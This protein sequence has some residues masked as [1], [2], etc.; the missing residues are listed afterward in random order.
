MVGTLV[1]APVGTSTSR[2][3]VLTATFLLMMDASI[4]AL[5]LMPRGC[6]ILMTMSST[7]ARFMDPPQA[8]TPPTSSVTRFRLSASMATSQNVSTKS[9]VP[10]ALLMARED[11]LGIMTPAAATMDT[12]MGVILLPGTPPRLWKSN[13][14]GLSNSIMSPVLAMALVK[15]AI[16]SISM[17]L[18]YRAVSH[19]EISI[20]DSLLFR[21]STTMDSISSFD[22]FSPSIFLR[23]DLTESGFW[24]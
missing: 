12:T 18:M 21:M 11:S 15:S 7:G 6:S 3:V 23:I 20:L 22:S 24:Q 8:N 4:C 14:C 10:H 5:G 19:A 16:S 9:D 1:P 2:C 13:T 17:P